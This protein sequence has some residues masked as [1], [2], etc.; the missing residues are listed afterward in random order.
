M[1][2]NI[3]IRKYDKVIAIIFGLFTLAIIMAMTNKD[4]FSW[5]W[6]RHHN[7]LSWYIRPLFLIPF[8]YFAYK[9]SW[10]GISATIFLLISSM[11]W[12]L[13]PGMA[14]EQVNQFLQVEIDYLN[15][16]WGIGKIL[17]TL[18]VP[19]SLFA[20]GAAFWKRNLLFGISVI[21]FIALAKILWSVVFG[22]ESGMSILAPA[23]IGL[24]ICVILIYFGFRRSEKNN[25]DQ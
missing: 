25:K 24:I 11:F 14:S 7:I 10:A 8:C 19:I 15:A 21:V 22:G 2:N 1:I 17:M 9:R 18:I 13:E 3:E 20:L 4:F 5:A 16:P 23:I 6:A 12:F